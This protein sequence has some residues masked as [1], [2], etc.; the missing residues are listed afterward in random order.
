MSLQFRVTAAV[1]GRR[2]A[3]AERQKEAGSVWQFKVAKKVWNGFGQQN[4]AS[5]VAPQRPAR[6]N[7][8]SSPETAK[9]RSYKSVS[10]F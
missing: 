5:K 8:L 2:T 10:Y 9:E 3:P 4:A 1:Q 6:G 7:P